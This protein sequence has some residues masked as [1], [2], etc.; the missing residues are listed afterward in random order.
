LKEILV[1][2]SSNKNIDSKELMLLRENYKQMEDKEIAKRLNR[3]KAS[4]YAKRYRLNLK[5]R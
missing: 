3:T 4:I 5:K 2:I 1:V